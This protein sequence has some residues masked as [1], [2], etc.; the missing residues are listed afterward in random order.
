MFA[1]IYL[2]V[3]KIALSVI[4]ISYNTC[5]ITKEC[6]SRLIPAIRQ[7]EQ[8]VGLKIEVIL[9]DNNS[10]DGTAD[11]VKKNYPW[12]RLIVSKEN[13]GYAKANNLAMK[14]ARGKYFLLL[15][16]DAFVR[17]NT[18]VKTWRFGGDN[19]YDVVACRLNYK[20]EELQPSAGFLPN[21]L[22]ITTWMLGI[23]NFPLI[24][25][26]APPVHVKYPAFFKKP[27]EIGWAMGAFMFLK[28]EVFEITGGFDEYYFMYTEEVEWFKRIHDLGFKVMYTPNF[29]IIH[30]DKASSGGD[31]SRA[32]IA[33][34]TGLIYYSKKHLSGWTG[35]I[36][37]LIYLGSFWRTVGFIA[38]GRPRQ[39]LAHKK[40]LKSI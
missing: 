30:L 3:Q 18:L 38:L 27:R 39:A 12:V 1:R 25:N 28:R 34:K 24:R 9:V 23:A 8:S 5:E 31:N 11:I 14:K 15:N 16:S 21:P 2:M 26:L 29:S 35:Y 7:F 36:R 40:V 17:K 33:E 6:L 10:S 4:I 20:N 19:K 22:N 37:L 32:I 13:L